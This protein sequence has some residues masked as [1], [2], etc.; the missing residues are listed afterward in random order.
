MRTNTAW[1]S[2]IALFAAVLGFAGAPGC[3]YESSEENDFDSDYPSC[4]PE[5]KA[6]CYGLF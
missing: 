6:L 2:V 4:E 3:F 5:D 1:I